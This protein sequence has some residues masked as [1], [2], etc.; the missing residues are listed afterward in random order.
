MPELQRIKLFQS[1]KPRPKQAITIVTQLSLER[2]H[3]LQQQCS[4]WPHPIAASLYIPLVQGKVFSA[5]NEAPLDEALAALAA[6]H[7]A[8]ENSINQ[9]NCILDL[10]IVVEEA[11]TSEK[12]V[13]NYPVNS[14]RNRALLL[15][16]TELVL[17]LDVDFI[18]DQDLATVTSK[19]LTLYS[20]LVGML[21]QGAA[22]VLPAFE[23]ADEGEAGIQLVTTAVQRG[24]SYLVPHLQNND[25]LPFYG[26][27]YPAGQRATQFLYWFRNST[28]KPYRIFYQESFEPYVLMKKSFVPFYDERFTGRHRDKMQHIMHIAVQSKYALIVHPYHFVIHLPHEKSFAIQHQ[29]DDGKYNGV[30]HTNQ[31]EAYYQ[32]AVEKTANQEFVPVIQRFSQFCLRDDGKTGV[33]QIGA[34][35]QG[36]E[37][38][39]FKLPEY[40]DS[41]EE[42]VDKY[43]ECHN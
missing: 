43:W 36:R 37:N 16:S 6:M 25:A 20:E 26:C 19:N 12:A 23:T 24:K 39:F 10:E 17:L 7:A 32:D 15:A 34:G 9:Q 35:E 38:S 1:H 28:I 41:N 31:M 18:V 40:I 14:L 42:G 29:D 21:S 5:G 11:C 3:M 33:Q 13:L 22:M 30:Q 27:T 4:L 2:L 8:S